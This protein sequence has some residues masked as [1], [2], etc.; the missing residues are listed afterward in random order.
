MILAML[1]ACVTPEWSA[2][3]VLAG[4]RAHADR[5]HDGTIT[6]DEL[7]ADTDKDGAVSNAELQVWIRERGE[8]WHVPGWDPPRRPLVEPHGIGWQ[9]VMTLRE[10]VRHAAPAADLPTDAELEA[11]AHAPLDDAAVQAL[12]ARLQPAASAA[13]VAIP[14]G[15]VVP[16]RPDAA[17]PGGTPPAAASPVAPRGED[18]PAA[19]DPMRA[20]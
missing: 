9:V 4:A 6:A 1:L 12:I 19:P 3:A 8:R 2:S 5:N 10:E 13:G 18:A 14:A 15:V 16:V 17:P 7:D 11:I 20:R